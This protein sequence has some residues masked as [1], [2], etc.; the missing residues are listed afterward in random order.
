MFGFREVRVLCATVLAGGVAYFIWTYASS[1]GKKKPK[2][3]QKEDGKNV[4]EGEGKK[5]EKKEE[6]PAVVVVVSPVVGAPVEKA[7]EVKR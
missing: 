5:E 7:S 3:R 2:T 4:S 6:E 1:S